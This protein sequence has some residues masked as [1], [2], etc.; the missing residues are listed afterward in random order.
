MGR[1]SRVTAR[2]V[3]GWGGGDSNPVV[4]VEDEGADREPHAAL[5]LPDGPHKTD[6]RCGRFGQRAVALEEGEQGV[7]GLLGGASQHGS[8]REQRPGVRLGR[9]GRG[10]DRRKRPGGGTSGG[11]A[12][13][14]VHSAGSKLHGVCAALQLHRT[15]RCLPRGEGLGS[16]AM[17]SNVPSERAEGLLVPLG[18]RQAAG[19]AQLRRRRRW[20]D[21]EHTLEGREGASD[22]ATLQCGLGLRHPLGNQLLQGGREASRGR[23]GRR[24][25]TVRVATAVGATLQNQITFLLAGEARR[26]REAPTRR[27]ARGEER[28]GDTSSRAASSLTA[29]LRPSRRTRIATGEKDVPRFEFARDTARRAAS[30]TEVEPWPV[31]RR[32][33]AAG[34]RGERHAPRHEGSPLLAPRRRQRPRGRCA[35]TSSLAREWAWERVFLHNRQLD[36]CPVLCVSA[37]PQLACVPENGVDAAIFLHA[38]GQWRAANPLPPARED[39]RRT[40]RF[41]RQLLASQIPEFKQYYIGYAALKRILRR[42]K[43][44]ERATRVRPAMAP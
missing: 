39:Q 29:A 20:H 24:R 32:Q 28:T 35:N 21:L 43:A 6:I 1:G 16:W 12:R 41:G 18:G 44:R 10:T 15:P 14:G 22:D 31:Q 27:A 36:R 30:A 8:P 25:W 38:A 26:V 40:M 34:Q 4:R 11:M 42:I 37:P 19:P 2:V 3:Q 5:P 33:R 13:E 7:G 9:G 23:R 17:F